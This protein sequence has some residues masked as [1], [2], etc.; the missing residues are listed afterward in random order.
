M[1]ELLTSKNL[2]VVCFAKSSFKYYPC[3]RI[4]KNIKQRSP[5]TLGTKIILSLKERIGCDWNNEEDR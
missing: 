3:N 1:I 5:V 2:E 4:G